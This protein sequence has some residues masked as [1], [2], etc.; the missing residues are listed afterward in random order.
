MN[1][2]QTST[3]GSRGKPTR[4]VDSPNIPAIPNNSLIDVGLLSEYGSRSFVVKRPTQP[5]RRQTLRRETT[6][7]LPHSASSMRSKEKPGTMK[8]K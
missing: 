4:I 7:C 3:A 5:A 8:S 6:S 1:F 2:P